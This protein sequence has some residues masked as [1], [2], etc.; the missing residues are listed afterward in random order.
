MPAHPMNK[1]LSRTPL[2]LTLLLAVGCQPS[3]KT[4]ITIDLPGMTSEA[5]R[6]QKVLATVNGVAITEAQLLLYKKNYRKKHPLARTPSR[7]ELLQEMIDQQLLVQLALKS[8]I[9]KKPEVYNQIL[10]FHNTLLADSM[11]AQVLKTFRVTD[12]DIEGVYLRRFQRQGARQYKT[13]NI[14]VP[15]GSVK[16]KC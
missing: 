6:T 10:F 1:A 8:G 4:P 16:T 9:G 7:Q 5:S 14:L 15:S 3:D 12:K 13:R 11:R 2:L